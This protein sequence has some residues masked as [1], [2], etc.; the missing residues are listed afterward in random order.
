[1]PV[2]ITCCFPAACNKE[3]CVELIRSRFQQIGAE[4][5]REPALPVGTLRS[6]SINYLGLITTLIMMP[7]E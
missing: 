5:F 1:M 6:Y 7:Q 3:R 2:L 4:F